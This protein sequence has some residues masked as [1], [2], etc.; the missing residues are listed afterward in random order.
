MRMTLTRR[1]YAPAEAFSLLMLFDAGIKWMRHP[2]V[3]ATMRQ[4]GFNGGLGFPGGIIEAACLIL[5]WMRRTAM[6]L[7]GLWARSWL[8]DTALRGMFAPRK[9]AA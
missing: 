9:M 7:T 5:F 4:L 6:P 8:R 2:L 1:Q 3:E